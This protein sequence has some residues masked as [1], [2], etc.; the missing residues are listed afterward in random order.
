MMPQ[1]KPSFL[2]RLGLRKPKHREEPDL[3]SEA[4]EPDVGAEMDWG[5][6]PPPEREP[7]FQPSPPPREEPDLSLE[8]EE[9][10]LDMGIEDVA[11]GFEDLVLGDE[12]VPSGRPEPETQPEPVRRAETASVKAEPDEGFGE[13]LGEDLDLGDL[14][15][16][17][18]EETPPQ[19]SAEP[20]ETGA[21]EDLGEDLDL[22]G[23]DLAEEGEEEAKPEAQAEPAAE[24]AP[25]E[26]EE[27]LG[28]DLD[29]EGL[30]LGEEDG[31]EDLQDLLGQ[32]DSEDI[33]QGLEDL[34]LGEFGAEEEEAPVEEEAEP[35]AEEEEAAGEEEE[36]G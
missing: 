33:L 18:E 36:E 8:G 34:D 7:I 10:G 17:E 14:D 28:E 3:F 27:D 32:E 2:E 6:Q 22:E 30:E 35:E 23:I 12:E 20:T 11:E 13:D 31:D 25:S 16:G 19:E 29:L 5:G 4:R 1:E 21:E 15:L 24:E 26:E 9:L